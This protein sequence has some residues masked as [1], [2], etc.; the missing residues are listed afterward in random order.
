L[1]LIDCIKQLDYNHTE[2]SRI[3]ASAWINAFIA[4]WLIMTV[5]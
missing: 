1:A 2:K 5:S 4:S 3:V